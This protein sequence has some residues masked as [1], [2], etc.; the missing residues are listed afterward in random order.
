MPR[1]PKN[2][3]YVAAC[4]QRRQSRSSLSGLQQR[5]IYQADQ[6]YFDSRRAIIG[7]N[8]L[9][10]KEKTQYL[11]VLT[12]ERLKA[13]QRITQP[14]G[15]NQQ[16]T[17]TMGSENIRQHVRTR[18]T[19]KNSISGAEETEK[20]PVNARQRFARMAGDIDH[21]LGERSIR[22]KV[23]IIT[24]AD[25]YTRK[26]RL[27]EN[28]HYL[29]KSSDKTLFVDTGKSIAVSKNG[30]SESA[31]AV[32]LELAKEK[33]G[34]TLTVKGSAAFKD[35]VIEA[36]AQKGMDVHFTDKEMNRRLAERK[37]ELA[38]EREGQNISQ[39]A[40]PVAEPKTREEFAD[41]FR[42]VEQRYEDVLRNVDGMSTAEIN[43]QLQEISATR[44]ALTAAS[45]A[46]DV[47]AALDTTP[48]ETSESLDDRCRNLESELEK[49]SE[50]KV[51]VRQPLA[52]T[53]ATAVSESTPASAVPLPQTREELVDAFRSVEQRYEDVLS[54][55]D[56]MSAGEIDKQL[57]QIGEIRQSLSRASLA[58]DV[59]ASLNGAPDNEGES[60]DDRSRSLESQ[61]QKLSEVKA[62]AEQPQPSNVSE[63]AQPVTQPGTRE[64]FVDAFRAV[65][66]RYTDVLRNAPGMSAGEIRESLQ[67]IRED[68]KALTRASLSLDVEASL[69]T[70]PVSV[71]NSID[72][73]SRDLEAR[74]RQVAEARAAAQPEQEA[75]P[76][77]SAPENVKHIVH[78]GVLLE[79]GEAPYQFKPDMR[80]PEAE[81]NDSYF[82]RLQKPDGAEKIVWGVTL[83]KA[84]AGLEAGENIRLE[85]MG[86]ETVQWTQAMADGS[87]E[88]RT[89]ERVAW[90][91]TSI[92]RDVDHADSGQEP[93]YQEY[94]TWEEQDYG[95]DVA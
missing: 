45:L 33:F 77:K 62:A 48:E 39:G 85:N 28:I 61:L 81:R 72:D 32:A 41:A 42:A 88:Q 66:E 4:L 94:E 6:K 76:A 20:Q 7:D 89:G 80:K 54:T 59:E 53:Q 13:H 46:L 15:L 29:D 52:E 8:R 5:M 27:S 35:T 58:I 17:T 30:M 87:T 47:E 12:F 49:L 23:R 51:S 63:G 95:P 60:L 19:G 2:A 38:I 21:N 40:E 92:D 71:S 82:V 43:K 34:S 73:R 50:Q 26:S 18:R 79:H 70:A 22:E 74:L 64:E 55:A 83:E 90:K 65:E 9:T 44:K 37:A 91:G 86:K 56:G 69:G 24:A 16:E 57:Q 31:V 1:P 68:R 78:E 14:E 67:S 75:Q 84:V 10:P 93:S 36:V 11:A 3:S 25:L